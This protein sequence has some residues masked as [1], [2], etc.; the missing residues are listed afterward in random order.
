MEDSLLNPSGYH[1]NGGG[2]GAVLEQHARVATV[3]LGEE[4]FVPLIGVREDTRTGQN[5]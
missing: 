3:R 5:F 4:K 2:G 1:L